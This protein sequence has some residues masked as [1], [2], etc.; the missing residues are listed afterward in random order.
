MF[1]FFKKNNI[2]KTKIVIASKPKEN[3]KSFFEL[4]SGEQ[5][6]IIERATEKANQ[7]QQKLVR[8]HS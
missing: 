4:S 7:E 6:K 2:S 1:N 8:A 5:K 3:P